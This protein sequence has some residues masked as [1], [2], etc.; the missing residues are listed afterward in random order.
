MKP[1]HPTLI[2]IAVLTLIPIAS[3]TT[4]T[5]DSG[6][7]TLNVQYLDIEALDFTSDGTEFT[8]ALHLVNLQDDQLASRYTIHLGD[9]AGNEVTLNCYFGTGIFLVDNPSCQGG[10]TGASIGNIIGVST[11]I[12]VT[13]SLDT[14]TD[15]ITVTVPYA[16]IDAS[17]GD[18]IIVGSTASSLLVAMYA[19][20]PGDELE[21]NSTETLA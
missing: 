2:A 4:Y 6:D 9:P 7:A 5:D 8:V 15:V 3:A 13:W 14:T 1:N 20:V 18:E 10:R 17:S 12:T 16:E 11:A 21:I 19:P